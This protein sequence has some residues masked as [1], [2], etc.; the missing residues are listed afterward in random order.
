MVILRT[1]VLNGDSPGDG[2]GSPG[3]VCYDDSTAY[4]VGD[5]KKHGCSD[6]Y[7]ELDGGW[8]CKEEPCCLYV[9]SRTGTS[10]TKRA[11]LEDTFH[12]GC[13]KCRCIANPKGEALAV[14]TMQG[15]PN[16]C[17][18]HNWE[19]IF[20]YAKIGEMIHVEYFTEKGFICPRICM[21]KK[22]KKG[23]RHAEVS[24]TSDDGIIEET[25]ADN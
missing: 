9:D 12:D 10:A 15:C 2:G 20:G 14:C 7:C 21:C 8:K 5:M 3:A 22:G 18:Y 23:V 19:G 6:C 1:N 24:C 25:C 13:N 4:Q 16:K 11:S 17:N